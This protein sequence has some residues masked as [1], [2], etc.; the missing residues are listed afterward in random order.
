MYVF[1]SHFEFPKAK[2]YRDKKSCISQN[3]LFS[4]LNSQ[5]LLYESLT[6][7]ITYEL[8]DFCYTIKADWKTF[9]SSL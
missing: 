2:T 9:F 3:I 7:E 8:F 4:I 6:T 5:I 1:L